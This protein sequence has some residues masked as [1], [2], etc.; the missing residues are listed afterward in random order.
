VVGFFR[1]KRL[2][3]LVGGYW[4]QIRCRSGAFHTL[5]LT[6]TQNKARLGPIKNIYDRATHSTGASQIIRLG[7]VGAARL[8]DVIQMAGNV[9]RCG[10]RVFTFPHSPPAA[11]PAAPV[12]DCHSPRRP[13]NM[14]SAEADSLAGSETQPDERHHKVTVRLSSISRSR[15]GYLVSALPESTGSGSR[16]SGRHGHYGG[17]LFYRTND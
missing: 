16:S 12:F 8:Q 17:A 13:I 14:P 15:P 7:G 3:G 10:H 2:L 6:Q 4:G 11:L 9:Q 5:C 1:G